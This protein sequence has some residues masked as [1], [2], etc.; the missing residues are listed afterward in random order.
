MSM[1][2]SEG[3]TVVACCAC[4]PPDAVYSINVGKSPYFDVDTLCPLFNHA[5]IDKI[6]SIEISEKFETFGDQSSSKDF[7]QIKSEPLDLLY[8]SFV[9]SASLHHHHH[10]HCLLYLSLPFQP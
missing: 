3:L 1:S 4:V 5:Y 6:P 8:G 10:H 7:V 9:S 2:L